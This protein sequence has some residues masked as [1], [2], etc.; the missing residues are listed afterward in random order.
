MN[1]VISA[2]KDTVSISLFNKGLANQIFDKVK[3]EGA[4]VVLKQNEPICVLLAPSEYLEMME[5]LENA[6]MLENVIRRLKEDDAAISE[7]YLYKHLNI[8][9]NDLAGWEDIEIE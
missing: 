8:T 9:E 4:K 2:L 1:N 5:E 7:K 3:N 6:K